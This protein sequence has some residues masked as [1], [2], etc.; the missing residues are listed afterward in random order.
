MADRFSIDISPAVFQIRDI[1][2]NKVIFNTSFN[3][4]YYD[5]AGTIIIPSSAT[6]SGT[7][8]NLTYRFDD[9]ERV[10]PN[11]VTGNTLPTSFDVYHSYF[12]SLNE[13]ITTSS[14][15]SVQASNVELPSISA[16]EPISSYSDGGD[17]SGAGGA[18]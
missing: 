4:L 6:M 5:P 11:P 16:G 2:N 17:G 18:Y 9:L 13:T 10:V 1:Q 15:V 14:F 7:N 8:F 12:R 3:Y